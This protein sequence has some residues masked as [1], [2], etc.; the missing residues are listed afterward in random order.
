MNNNNNIFV[1]KK[2]SMYIN[3]L[4]LD[5]TSNS[6]DEIKLEITN[7]DKNGDQICVFNI[8]CNNNTLRQHSIKKRLLCFSVIND[9][10]C[11]YNS[12]CKFAH[13]LSEQN[14]DG[15]IVYIYQIILDKEL[16]NYFSLLNPKT[17]EL[18]KRLLFFTHVCPKCEIGKCMGGYNCKYGTHDKCLKICKNDLLTGQCINKIIEIHVDPNIIDKI[19]P[20]TKMDCY[21]GCINGHHLSERNLI[22]YY[23]YINKKNIS[24]KT[25]CQSV[26]YID[27][28]PVFFLLKNNNNR[29]FSTKN[30]ISSDSSTSSSMDEEINQLFRKKAEDYDDVDEDNDNV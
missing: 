23:T 18:Y 17:D 3:N 8:P 5:D 29:R 6:D 13:T 19:N 11:G 7:Y 26:R 4:E 12:L 25:T 1:H 2:K 14:I 22:P 27:T 20:T 28:D 15:E 10:Q 30:A 9:E 16:M 21:M 24:K